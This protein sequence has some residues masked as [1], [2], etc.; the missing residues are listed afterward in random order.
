MN[1]YQ[2]V[3]A[4]GQGSAG[5]VVRA[6]SWATGEEVAI[7]KLSRQRFRRSFDEVLLLRE[8]VA[9]RRL[10]HGNIV[11]L[12]EIIREI[13][14][15]HLVF[16]YVQSSLHQWIKSRILSNQPP[17]EETSAASIVHRILL[18][19]QF[20]HE[21]GLFH[22]DLKP[23]NVLVS[24]DLAILK[25]ADFG[26]ARPFR[27]R[28]GRAGIDPLT[29][30]VATRWY[31]APEI[32]LRSPQYS[33]PVDLWA[34]GC[35]LAEV[36]MM[37]PLFPGHSEI[38]Q[39][40]RITAMLGTPTASTWQHGTKL[41]QQANAPHACGPA[42]PACA[43]QPIG[44]VVSRASDRGLDLLKALLRWDANRRLTAAQCLRHAYFRVI[45]VR[46]SPRIMVALRRWAR[47]VQGRRIE[48]MDV[49]HDAGGNGEQQADAL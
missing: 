6:R 11:A 19:T 21:Q 43:P 48:E 49:V 39:L 13:D 4:C 42:F 45:R 15:I 7:K 32:L 23:A 33:A 17:P 2:V 16:E 27:R 3:G 40:Q 46:G 31:R 38:D 10:R 41:M 9:L 22:R 37:Q 12:R 1:R 29:G 30:Y 34:I 14:C 25:I 36:T 47:R 8:V 26:T 35:I 5:D 18:G 20:M 44:D 28:N 24:E